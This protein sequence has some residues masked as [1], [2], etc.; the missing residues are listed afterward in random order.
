MNTKIVSFLLILLG[1]N[2]NYLAYSQVDSNQ[3][4]KNKIQ[5]SGYVE[6]YYAHDFS[7]PSDHNRPHFLYSFHRHNEVNLNFGFI[8]ADYNNEKI[9]GKLALMA[10][11]Y[12][13]ANLAQEPGVLKNVYEA[14]A[15]FKLSKNKNIWI[16]AGVFASHLGF[17]SAIGSNC[18]TLTRSLVTESSPYYVSGAKITYISS[19]EKWLLSGLLLNGW[20]RIQRVK[21]N[22]TPAFG[23]QVT[24]SPTSKITVNSSSFVGSNTPDSLLKMR[25][26]HNLYGQFQLH[27]KWAIIVGFDI[28]AEQKNKKS[29]D[30]NTWYAPIAIMRFTPNQ[31]FA[32]ALRTE[33][34]SDKNEVIVATGTPNGFQIWGYSTN[35]DVKITEKAL[36]RLEARTFNSIKD[37]I[38]V[39]KSSQTTSSNYFLVT[40][41]A[42][43]F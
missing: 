40:S 35:I 27:E 24:W 18:W 4:S 19:N 28:G 6:V 10:G 14:N 29:N 43:S 2:F 1:I 16:D 7:Q 17:E 36:W 34:Y 26:F 15:G 23:H 9:R 21:G 39:N 3:L 41:I 32:F 31:K 37:P 42:L 13:N 38:F 33:Y 12:S 22:Q 8:Q 30:Y 5:L 25:Y 11:T 20:Q